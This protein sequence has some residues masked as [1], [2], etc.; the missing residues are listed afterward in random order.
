MSRITKAI[1]AVFKI[2]RNPWLLNHVLQQP[3]IWKDH[4]FKKYHIEEGLGVISPEE[5]FGS[6]K[7]FNLNLFT[8]LDG[9]S[10]V[11]DIV[12]LKSLAST[13]EN[14]SYFEIGTWR[15]ESLSN[16]ADVAEVCYS[17]NLSD[18]EMREMGV[19]EDYIRLQAFFSRDLKNVHHLKGNSKNFDFSSLNRKFDLIFIDGSHHYDDVKHDT[20]QVFK[21][22]IHDKS[23]VVWHDYG[24][25]PEH[26]RY[27]V[28][29]GILD[30]LTP[31]FQPFL[32]HVAHTKSAVY[33]PKK[34]KTSKL[35]T[36]V[37]PESFYKV[38]I[39]YQKI[40]K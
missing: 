13:F 10:L 11:T 25:T 6:E 39:K 12:L 27:E 21:H 1:S 16:V 37:Y 7:E 15:G 28:F 8:F 14:C 4:V 22:L 18:N 23:V 26:I 2:L 30:G 3:E 36:P 20:I 32:Y 19:G 33:I 35:E 17:L 5:L 38:D 24:D 9:G 31:E 34:L 29:A 40:E